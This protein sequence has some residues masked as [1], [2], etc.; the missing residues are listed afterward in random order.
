MSASFVSKDIWSD[1]TRSALRSPA[2]CHVAVAYFAS[3]ASQLLPLGRGSRLVVDASEKAVK[4]G[5]TC[6]AELIK[7]LKQGVEIFSVP[8][9]HAKV[10][11]LGKTAYIGSANVST[12]SASTLIEAGIRI[13]EP[14]VIKAARQ[15]VQ[16]QCLHQLTPEVLKYLAKIYRPPIVTGNNKGKRP[17]KAGSTRPELPPLRLAQLHREDWPELDQATHDE[18]LVV[19]EKRRQHKTQYLLESFRHAGKCPYK[20]KDAVIQ[21]TDEGGGKILLS[22]PG[23]VLHVRRMRNKEVSFVYL[24]R[25][26][27][28]RRQLKSVAKAVG[29]TQKRLRKSGLVKDA[30]LAESLFKIWT[31]A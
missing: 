11:V 3:G 21:A 8:N 28:K 4:S 15:F 5:Q 7:L 2:S 9:L 18:A 13:T 22:P 26:D 25:P 19:A 12:R 17:P 24:E 30:D 6:P 29:S 31:N 14:S 16:K 1:L 27:R 20:G 23:N 10:F